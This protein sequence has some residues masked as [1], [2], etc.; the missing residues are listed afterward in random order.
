MFWI[1]LFVHF[2]ETILTKDSFEN[3]GSWF[4]ADIADI[5]F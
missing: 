4:L 2:H 1:F 5:V 3:I